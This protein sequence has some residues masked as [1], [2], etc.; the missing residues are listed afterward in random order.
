MSSH[1]NP[2]AAY[3]PLARP[4]PPRRRRGVTPMAFG[5]VVLLLL[6]AAGAGVFWW[7]QRGPDHPDE[8]D[9]RVLEYVDF[10]EKERG[11]DFEHPVYVDFLSEKA[12]QEEVTSDA[13]DLA[14]DELAEIEQTAGLMRAIGLLDPGV[15]LFAA[16]NDLMAGGVI[17]LYDPEDERI[18]MR[19][20]ELTPDVRSTLV[21]ELTHALQ[22][23]HFDLEEKAEEHEEDD[24]TS[25]AAVWS[26]L[27][28]GDADRIEN[29]WAASLPAAER[30][31]VEKAQA[32]ASESALE[33]IADV[34]PFLTTLLGSPYALGA[35]LVGLTLELDGKDAVDGLF[36]S[37]PTSEEGLVDPWTAT[38]RQ[39]AWP[40]DEPDVPDGTERIE[41][42]TFG[43]PSLLFMLAERISPRTAL[44]ATDG[45]GGDQY[46]AYEQDDRT[47]VRLDYV[48][49]SRRDVVELTSALRT[50]IARGPRGAA[51][52]TTEGDGLRLQACESEARP[53]PGTGG[54]ETAL[55]LV[56]LRTQL[57]QEL[58]SS[59]TP[60]EF[61]R[62]YSDVVVREFTVEELTTEKS[63]PGFQRRIEKLA[64]RCL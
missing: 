63:S 55:Q 40:V 9:P 36:E 4:A 53:R 52:V 28:E 17:G 20:T 18:R 24:D 15:D 25:A 38:E 46:V 8:W 42:G 41:A 21:H 26:A 43:A 58:L 16:V 11:L 37:P 6:G 14:E 31:A 32:A 50:W 2:Y 61:S 44:V 57:A 1:E 47:C 51:S 7:T 39:A 3:D 64:P 35:G 34:P 23:Q 13:S 49:D 10:V 54:S 19:G 12:F 45:W 59:D 22:D 27:L 33:Q 30:K 56:A 62:C 5:I 60:K 29:A 48:G